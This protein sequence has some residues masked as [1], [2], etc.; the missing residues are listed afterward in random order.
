M[1]FSAF[2]IGIRKQHNTTYGVILPKETSLWDVEN[3]AQNIVRKN[4]Y[5]TVSLWEKKWWGSWV[6]KNNFAAGKPNL[7]ADRTVLMMLYGRK[8]VLIN[9]WMK[10]NCYFMAPISAEWKS[11]LVLESRAQKI[12]RLTAVLHCWDCWFNRPPYDNCFTRHM[13]CNTIM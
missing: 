6:V 5:F 9:R 12:S 11:V 3:L 1:D 4:I 2:S 13:H 7:L 8:W 10:I